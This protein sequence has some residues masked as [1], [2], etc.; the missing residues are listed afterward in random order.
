MM[1]CLYTICYTYST[2]RFVFKYNCGC[3]HLPTAVRNN[4]SNYYNRFGTLRKKKNKIIYLNTS[5]ITD[6]GRLA[7][8]VINVYGWRERSLLGE[9]IATHIT[10]THKKKTDKDCVT[11]ACTAAAGAP[12][13]E[14]KVR[15]PAFTNTIISYNIVLIY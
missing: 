7:E 2:L 10:N 5:Y 6:S 11:S 15:E 9:F 3:V 14:S 4:G 13:Y 12:R 8:I 1:Y